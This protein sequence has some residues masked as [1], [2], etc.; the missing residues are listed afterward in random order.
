[1]PRLTLPQFQAH[2]PT[3]SQPSLSQIFRLLPVPVTPQTV[4]LLGH[5]L[6][7][8]FLTKPHQLVRPPSSFPLP[9]ETEQRLLTASLLSPSPSTIGTCSRQNRLKVQPLGPTRTFLVERCRP[10]RF[11][12]DFSAHEGSEKDAGIG[13]NS[14][15]EYFDVPLEGLCVHSSHHSHFSHPSCLLQ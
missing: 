15:P 3:T 13:W 6:L 11:S 14:L 12:D 5:V 8:I 4:L 7:P 9:L 1:M 10:M 2:P